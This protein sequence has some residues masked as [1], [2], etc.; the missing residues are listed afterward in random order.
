VTRESYLTDISDIEWELIKAHIPLAKGIGRPR[1]HS[2]REIINA[3]FYLL[4]SGCAWRLLPHDFP[5]GSRF[6]IISASGG[7]MEFGS[8]LIEF[9]D[10][11]C[12]S[13]Q[14]VRQN[15]APE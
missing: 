5:N 12:A 9:C 2:F 3:I 15:Q 14:G 11:N 8:R 10:E 6:I 13:N 7:L 1:K 4:K